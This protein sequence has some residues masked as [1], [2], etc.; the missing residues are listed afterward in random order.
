MKKCWYNDP[1]LRPTFDELVTSIENIITK[2]EKKGSEGQTTVKHNYDNVI[3]IDDSAPNNLPANQDEGSPS[4][5]EED[6][7]DGYLRPLDNIDCS[8][9]S[10]EHLQLVADSGSR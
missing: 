1:S 7:E 5:G 9:L 6:D 2:M 3:V 4:D 8:S 10:T